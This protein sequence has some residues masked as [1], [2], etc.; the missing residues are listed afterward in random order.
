METGEQAQEIGYSKGNNLKWA[1]IMDG[2]LA[3]VFILMNIPLIDVIFVEFEYIDQVSYCF[4]VDW[5]WDS[6]WEGWSYFKQ[7][8]WEFDI[9]FEI[10]LEVFDF[11]SELD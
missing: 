7:L 3:K 5:V 1:K 8:S 6:R 10:V 4:T 2:M 9:I 11:F